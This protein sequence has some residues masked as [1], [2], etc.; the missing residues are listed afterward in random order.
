MSAAHYRLPFDSGAVGR[1]VVRDRSTEGMRAKGE[2]T[3]KKSERERKRQRQ[4]EKKERKGTENGGRRVRAEVPA[5]TWSRIRDSRL[6]MYRDAE[7]EYHDT[8]DDDDTA[9]DEA[10]IYYYLLLFLITTLV[11]SF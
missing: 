4:T 7:I 5:A 3:K 2:R 8:R 1:M 6:S 10:D 9:Y 11:R